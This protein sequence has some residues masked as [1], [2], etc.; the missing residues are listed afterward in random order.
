MEENI[1]VLMLRNTETG[2]LER[3][4]A[5]FC[6]EDNG[7]LV[8]LTATE[9]EG[10]YLVH[11]KASTAR[12]VLD[13]EFN[14]IYDYYDTDIYAEAGM[15]CAEFEDC[16]NPTWEITFAWGGSVAELAGVVGKALFLHRSELASVYE[17]IAPLRVE[18]E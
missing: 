10:G 4:L 6:T 3:E 13:W 16:E 11:A 7:L 17:A 2:F 12:D 8:N 1:I 18:Y 9:A 15:A 14:A 5:A